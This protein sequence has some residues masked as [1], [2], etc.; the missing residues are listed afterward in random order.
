VI[1]GP[2]FAQNHSEVCPIRAQ[3]R[4]YIAKYAAFKIRGRKIGDAVLLQQQKIV[5]A[6]AQRDQIDTGIRNQLAEGECGLRSRVAGMQSDGCLEARGTVAIVIGASV[7]EAP[8][9]L[10]RTGSVD[11]RSRLERVEKG[12]HDFGVS[13]V[14]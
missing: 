11:F 4:V 9:G 6:D 5:A 7:Q 14:L 13:D 8:A 3:D 2:N 1:D 12:R 10:A